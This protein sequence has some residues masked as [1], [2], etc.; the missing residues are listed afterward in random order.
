MSP[1]NI[2][3]MA[4]NGAL[5]TALNASRVQRARL[6]AAF[7]SRWRATTL[8]AAVHATRR[9]L[10]PTPQA[11]QSPEAGVAALRRDLARCLA[12]S[13]TL[14]ESVRAAARRR[15]AER[16]RL[17]LTPS[18]VEHV[19][20]PPPSKEKA[21]PGARRVKQLGCAGIRK[22]YDSYATKHAKKL[23]P[24]AAV[25]L[26]RDC[27]VLPQY[28]SADDV[29]AAV[30]PAPINYDGFCRVVAELGHVCFC[31]AIEVEGVG[32]VTVAKSADD[33]LRALFRVISSSKAFYA[34]QKTPAALW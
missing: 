6:R 14:D 34:A 11:E 32:R 33:P 24:D 25:D 5:A 29:L 23:F 7:F 18:K 16:R 17:P 13:S 10:D 9:L 27:C 31:R 8:A 21:P 19:P 15:G 30:G 20:V 26:F 2:H 28:A 12:K 22:L 4:V 3:R 1:E